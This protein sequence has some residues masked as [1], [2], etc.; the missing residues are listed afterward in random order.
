MIVFFFYILGLSNSLQQIKPYCAKT[1]IRLWHQIFTERK[2]SHDFEELLAPKIDG[3]FVALLHYD[4]IKAIG[5]LRENRLKRVAYC[6]DQSWAASLL[7]Q[8]ILQS[9]NLCIDYKSLKSQT[10]WYYESIYEMD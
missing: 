2:V 7:I 5:H 1:T 6:P 9:P 3:E 4:E 10:R 8:E